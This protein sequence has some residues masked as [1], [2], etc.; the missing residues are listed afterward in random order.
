MRKRAEE[1]ARADEIGGRRPMS[2][3]EAQRLLH[4]LRVHQ[5]ELEMQNEELRRAQA[6]LDASRERYFDLYDLA[7]VGYVSISEK[8]LILEANL[9]AATLLGVGK[10]E[11][12]KQPLT[13]FIL[14]EDQDAY[15]RH[16]RRVLEEGTP[17]SRELRL[18][19]HDGAS[20]WALLEA[21]TAL[22]AD[23]ARVCRAVISDISKRKRAEE[24]SLQLASIVDTSTDAIIGNAGRHYHQL[25]QGR[26]E[27]IRLPRG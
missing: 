18:L 25:E 2:P 6:E 11:L 23:G 1:K 17:Q 24:R 8:G 9:A 15:Y 10:S 21:A 3:E 4:E 22:D 19:K 13:R 27:N 7:P 14:S 26:R 12:A 20:F 16:W 5:I